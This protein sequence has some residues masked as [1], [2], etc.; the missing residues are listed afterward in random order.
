M[1]KNIKYTIIHVND[2]A[3]DNMKRNKKILGD[4]EYVS[5]ISF[6][7]GNTE[8]A[9]KI[10]KDIGIDTTTWSP[11]DKR[12]LPVFPGEYGAWVSNINVW[13]FMLENNVDK[14]LVLEDDAIL[15]EFAAHSLN[16][17]ISELPKGWDSLSLFY[18]DGQNAFTE[19]TNIQKRHI[20]KNL[21]QPASAVAML[22]SNS[23]ARKLLELVKEKG[24]EY[25][26]DCFIHEQGRLGLLNGYSI[27][28]GRL[29]FAS[30]SI[31]DLGSTIDPDKK[32]DVP[33]A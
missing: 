31:E 14:M 30:H 19:Q 24:I 6:C 25:A 12:E 13:T 15:F 1:V 20:H 21:N 4:L 2:R 7:N 11:Y 18:L 33:L 5:E 26:H 22:Y 27:I 9:E 17:F 10:L 32:R 8:D 29:K 23:G 28:P 3:Q 16:S